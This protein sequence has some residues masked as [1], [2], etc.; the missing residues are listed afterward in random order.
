VKR[1]DSSNQPD[2]WEE[3]PMLWVELRSGTGFVWWVR[4]GQIAG[5]SD[6]SMAA[7]RRNKWPV[8]ARKLWRMLKQRGAKCV[9]IGV[10]GSG[11]GA[12]A[13]QALMERGSCVSIRI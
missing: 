4:A 6:Y 2:D 1:W 10:D 11:S 9:R 7:L 8:D 5:G 12:R 3:L 13:Q